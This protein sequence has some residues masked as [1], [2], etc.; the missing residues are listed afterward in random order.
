MTQGGGYLRWLAG[1]CLTCAIAAPTGVFAQQQEPLPTSYPGIRLISPVQGT[2][3]RPGQHVPVTVDV[4]PALN[5]R[6]VLIAGKLFET[7]ISLDM[8]GPP[9]T[10][11]LKIPQNLA[12][13]IELAMIVLGA[14]RKSVGGL[15]I[16]LNIVPADTPRRLDISRSFNLKLPPS[17]FLGSRTIYVMGIYDGFERLISD[18]VTGT[19][20]RSTDTGVVTVDAHGV[21]MPV[22]PGQAFIVVEHRGLKGFTRVEV[23]GKGKTD[24]VFAPIDY[25]SAVSMSASAPR[26]QPDS[27]RYD[28]EVS[29]HNDSDLPLALPLHLVIT[30]L[31]EGVR[32]DG[33]KTKHIK[34]IGS[35]CVFVSV[36]EQDFLSPG[37]S[38]SVTVEFINFDDK[39]LHH[40]LQLY[41]GRP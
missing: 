11:M 8:D 23:E 4:D 40:K 17:T 24:R 41:S 38:A 3:V 10:G 33:S 28:M 30:G 12:G 15:G 37:N 26:K 1:V 34:P 16:N 32:V 29:I 20:Y 19:H 18:P 9:F 21:L 22:A 36:D 5:A 7:G 13:S 39:P 2:M 27:V 6:A 14:D 25:T 35:P 31:A